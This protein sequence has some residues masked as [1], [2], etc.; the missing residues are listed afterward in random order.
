MNGQMRQILESIA[1]GILIR[2]FVQKDVQSMAF[3]NRNM[4]V[5]GDKDG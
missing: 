5:L 1:P 4:D 2:N 3:R